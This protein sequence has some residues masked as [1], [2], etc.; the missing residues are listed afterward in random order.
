MANRVILSWLGY[1]PKD[2]IVNVVLIII[3]IL[4]LYFVG[5]F[6][7]GKFRNTLAANKSLQ[8]EL[9]SGGVLSYNDVKYKEYADNLYL[10]MKG[11]GT[12]EDKI[13]NVFYAMKT[14]ADV[15]KLIAVYGIN[16]GEDLKQWL[17]GDLSRSDIQKINGILTSNRIDYQF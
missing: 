14:K 13:F 3:F 7:Y 15:L 8:E 11:W 16:D 1:S 6:L 5:K 10:A 4:V 9:D 2:K 12:D 17:Y